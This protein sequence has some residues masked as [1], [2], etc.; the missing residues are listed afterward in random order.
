MKKL[1]KLWKRPCKGGQEYKYVLIWKDEQGKER[2]KSLGHADSRKAER[3]RTQKEREL[4]MGTVEPE[5]M[6]LSEFLD[7]SLTLTGNQIRESTCKEYDF[8]MK[9]FIDVV[10]DIDYKTIRQE[11]AE[12]FIQKALDNGNRPATVAKKI[13]HLKRM[14]QLAVERGQL[15]INPLRYIKQPKTPKKKI[16]IFTPDACERMIRAA[17]E[18]QSKLRWDLLIKLALTTAMRR[19][20]LLNLTWSDIDFELGMIEVSPKTDTQFTWE[21]YIK[22]TDRRKLPLTEELIQLLAKHQSEQPEGYPYVFVPPQRYDH[23]QELRQQN[24]WNFV[25]TRL[26]IVQNFTRDYS[27]ILK[28][29]GIEH[30]QFHDLRRTALSG[31]L[32]CGMSEHDVMVL[33]G[34]SNFATTHEFYLATSDNMLKRA[35]KVSELFMKNIA[36]PLQV[37]FSEENEKGQQS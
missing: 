36:N 13:R 17:K 23:I 8:A 7:N 20:E 34:H 9:N 33:A 19:G 18:T 26:K 28:N 5:S 11:H 31:W 21:W 16:R 12:R 37:P 10:G 4:R 27:Q 2:W 14:F 1:V 22:D 24:K 15:E 25:D 29:A 32:H 3:Q 30:G 35:K 6:K